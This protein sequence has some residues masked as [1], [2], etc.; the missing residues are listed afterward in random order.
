MLRGIRFQIQDYGA[1]KK[2]FPGSMNL[3]Q[4]V[5]L[6]CK[7]LLL[8]LYVS[9]IIFYHLSYLAGNSIASY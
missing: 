3:K 4:S 1:V 9:N 6:F 5:N 8:L 7:K 2:I